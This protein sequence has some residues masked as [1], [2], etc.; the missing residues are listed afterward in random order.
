[1][2]YNLTKREKEIL[3]LRYKEGKT[4]AEIGQV[5]GVTR[6]RIRQI[7]AKAL[8]KIRMS[9]PEHTCDDCY[10]YWGVVPT[11]H[12]MPHGNKGCIYW[13][14]KLEPHEPDEGEK[15]DAYQETWN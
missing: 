4:L 15:Y 8:H 10:H 13:E 7:E 9:N 14:P 1:M 5:Y 3:R 12:H 2:N 6:E 11:C